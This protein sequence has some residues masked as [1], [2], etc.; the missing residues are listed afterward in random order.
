MRKTKQVIAGGTAIGGGAPITIQS[1]TNTDTADV[2]ATVEQ[3]LR[4]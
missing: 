1:M 2:N 4:L 3:I